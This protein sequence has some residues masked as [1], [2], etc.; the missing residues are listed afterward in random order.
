MQ[1]SLEDR[2]GQPV[3]FVSRGEQVWPK[4]RPPLAIVGV[5]EILH[6]DGEGTRVLRAFDPDMEFY[7][8]E[9]HGKNALLTY[10]EMAWA[11]AQ[12]T[13]SDLSGRVVMI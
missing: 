10:G 12:R 8:V 9:H 7:R 4:K 5:W 13:A 2:K 1:T 3:G 11:D 6:D